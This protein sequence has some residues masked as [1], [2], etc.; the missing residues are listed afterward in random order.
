MKTLTGKFAAA[1]GVAGLVVSACSS[2]SGSSGARDAD[3][4]R[5]AARAMSKAPGYRFRAEVGSGATVVKVQ[6]EFAQPDR[7]HETI[8]RPDGSA[9]ELVF[10]GAKGYA[11]DPTTGRWIN[12]ATATGQ[13]STDPRSAFGA[14]VSAQDIRRDQQ[15]YRFVLTGQPAQAL[16]GSGV[17]RLEGTATL[18]G[19]YITDLTLSAT[20]PRPL[21]LRLSY[22]DVGKAPPVTNP[23]V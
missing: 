19:T 4:F 18:G 17:T 20:A 5:A 12:S 7:V 3:R 11:K 16:G 2:G 8:T 9:V 6:G 15:R 13:S 23:A 10:I 1:L 21:S 14:L 22:T